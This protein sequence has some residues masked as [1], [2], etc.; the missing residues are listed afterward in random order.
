MKVSI[1]A[2]GLGIL[3]FANSCERVDPSKGVNIVFLHHSTGQLIWYGNSNNNAAKLLRK[4]YSGLAKGQLPNSFKK[5][6]RKH[7]TRYSI[8]EITFPKNEPYGWNNFPYDY[9]NIWVKNAGNELYMEEPTLE[10]LTAE[11]QIIILKHCYPVSTIQEDLDSSDINSDV[12]T[13]TNYKLQ[14]EALK[15]KLHQFPETKFIIFT[16]AVHVEAHL[17]KEEAIRAQQFNQWAIN[18]WDISDDNIFL[19]DLYALQTE[20][21]LYFKEEYSTSSTNSH[22]N[23]DFSGKAATLL[24]NRIIDVIETDGVTTSLTGELN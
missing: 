20:G 22:P 8:S 24:F 5:Y 6:N 17:E 1:L 7:N 19:W 21:E 18:E 2:I 12:K 3:L 15:N 10:I 16:G 23:Q 14:Y 4:I 11:Y 13:L 9:Y